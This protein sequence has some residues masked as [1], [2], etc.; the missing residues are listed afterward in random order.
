M[1]NM[2]RLSFEAVYGTHEAERGITI[3]KGE[4]RTRALQERQ[5]TAWIGK[6]LLDRGLSNRKIFSRDASWSMATIVSLL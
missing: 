2:R 6:E 5:T 1:R 4:V 3:S